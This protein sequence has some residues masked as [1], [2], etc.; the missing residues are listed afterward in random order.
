MFMTQPKKQKQKGICN[1]SIN[2]S[3]YFNQYTKTKRCITYRIIEI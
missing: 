3:N 2:I 1:Q